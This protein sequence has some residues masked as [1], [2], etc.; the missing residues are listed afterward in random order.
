MQ[1]SNEGGTP[2]FDELMKQRIGSTEN[3]QPTIDETVNIPIDG[4]SL[5]VEDQ[6]KPETPNNIVVDGWLT[7]TGKALVQEINKAITEGKTSVGLD[8]F[9]TAVERKAYDGYITHTEASRIIKAVTEYEMKLNN[10]S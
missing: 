6:S 8:P 9:I 5:E 7:E 2:I 4:A 10:L 1:E 3:T